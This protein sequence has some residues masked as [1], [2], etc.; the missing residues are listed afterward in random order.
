[1]DLINKTIILFLLK[2]TCNFYWVVYFRLDWINLYKLSY[3]ELH[4]ASL[5]Y[6]K[7]IVYTLETILEKH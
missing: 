7:A 5:S 3:L 2:E 4:R 6:L 1:M